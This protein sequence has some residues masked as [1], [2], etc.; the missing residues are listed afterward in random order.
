MEDSNFFLTD[1]QSI[2]SQIKDQDKQLQ[3]KRRW[4]MGLPTSKSK[5][6]QLRG[7]EF[8]KEYRSL[9]ET[10]LREDDI[11][12]ETIKTRVEESFGACTAERENNV[13]QNSSQLFDTRKLIRRL[14]SCLDALTNKGLFQVATLLTGGSIKFEKTQLQLKK[15]IRESLLKD[16]K[17]QNH[18]W[19]KNVFKRLSLILDDQRNFRENCGKFLSPTFQSHGAAASMVLDGLEDLPFQALISIHRKLRGVQGVIPNLRCYRHGKSRAHVINQVRKISKKMLSELGKEDELQEPLAKAMAVAGLSLK[20]K[21]GCQNSS[22][23]GFCQF[24]PEIK[25]LQNEIVKAIWLLKTKVRFRELKTVQNLLDPN[26]DVSNGSLRTAIKKMFIEYL[27]E[28]SDMDTIPKSLLET[29]AMINRSSRTAPYKCLPKEEIEEEVECVLSVSAQTKQIVWDL[30]PDHEFDQ[31]FA[32][33]YM[34]ELEESDDGDDCDFDNGGGGSSDGDI[35][36][37]VEI[38]NSQSCWFSSLESD[39]LAE[40]FG[41]SVAVNSELPIFATSGNGSCAHLTPGRRVSSDSVEKVEQ[42]YL[43]SVDSDLHGSISTPQFMESKFHSGTIKMNINHYQ[44]ENKD[45]VCLS[46]TGANSFSSFA[47]PKERLNSNSFGKHEAELNTTR[48]TRNLRDFFSSNLLFEDKKFIPSKQR[49]RGN[50]Y[51]TIQ[52]VCDETSV[53]AYNLIGHMLEKFA[54]EEEV[55]LDGNDSSYLRSNSLIQ[56]YTQVSGEKHTLSQEDVGTSVI[57]KMVE[58]LLPS[59]PKSGIEKLKKLM[60]A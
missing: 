39:D 6:K 3:L 11:F 17:N 2:L 49:T 23:L 59:L 1:C 41:D 51:V 40:G 60:D 21:P 9:P 50:Q 7:P 44:V 16:T 26:S 5:R 4:L 45:N 36:N 47:T 43:A 54:L 18:H 55:D 42:E 57:V 29:L 30:L 38:K 13:V 34:E 31:D 19:Q 53:V 28:S 20:L 10:M 32:D 22:D 14:L 12:Y 27:F 56:E 58:E 48:D 35:D 37:D 15:I 52:E 8:L 24:S 46:R 25:S 33:A